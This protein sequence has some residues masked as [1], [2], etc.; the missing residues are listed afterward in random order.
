MEVVGIAGF[1]S[2]CVSLYVCRFIRVGTCLKE[3]VQYLTY[4]TVNW[5]QIWR[6]TRKRRRRGVSR[7]VQNYQETTFNWQDH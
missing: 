1:E 6:A 4:D 2:C 5:R 3:E 7:F